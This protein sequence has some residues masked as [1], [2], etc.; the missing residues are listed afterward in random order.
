MDNIWKYTI[1]SAFKDARLLTFNIVNISSKENGA[2][3]GSDDED[4]IDMNSSMNKAL[5]NFFIL[6]DDESSFKDF[7]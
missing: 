5:L 4:D 2:S 3:S 6:D 1:I 7:S